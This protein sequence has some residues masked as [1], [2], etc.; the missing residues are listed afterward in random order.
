MA[1]GPSFLT[2]QKAMEKIR[3]SF[4][5]CKIG[6]K[7][8]NPI[9]NIYSGT[10]RYTKSFDVKKYPATHLFTSTWAAFNALANVRLN[11]ND[12]GLVWA[13][14]TTVDVSRYLKEKGNVLE[15][16]ITNTWHNRLVGDAQLPADQR[17]T[18]ATL[19]P[20][21]N[22]PL[23]P[24]GLIGPVALEIPDP[25][26]YAQ[27]VEIRVGKTMLASPDSTKVDLWCP[28]NDAIIYYT[29]DG[30][31]PT[32][33][34]TKYT[35]PITVYTQSTISAIAIKK[36]MK[37]SEISYQDIDVYNAE[38]NGFNYSY[39]EGNWNALPDF[40]TIKAIKSGK[41]SMDIGAI[42]NRD[43][44][45]AIRFDGFINIRKQG[46][47]TFFLSSDDGSKLYIN[48]NLVVDNDGSHGKTEK[49]GTVKLGIGKHRIVIEYFDNINDE[50]LELDYQIEGDIRKTVH[51]AMVT[52]D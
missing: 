3:S 18:H 37:P 27:K 40:N 47:Y 4:T 2:K 7:N 6:H 23:M 36:G 43:D 9:L 52:F 22:E 10:A 24:S 32:K 42:K 33:K 12:I 20:G 39:Y 46:N 50:A 17:T 19:Y 16:D 28:T 48:G 25:D 14:P 31:V 26:A 11:G 30:S 51:P 13:Y 38:V 8:R 44:H 21:I 45:F 1:I 29:L 34:S 41:G 5:N 49:S 15:V 35:G